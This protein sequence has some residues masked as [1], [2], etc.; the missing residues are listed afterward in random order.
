MK[1]I[2]ILE[3]I[4]SNSSNISSVIVHYD[5][6]TAD[7]ALTYSKKSKRAVAVNGQILEPTVTFNQ[8]HQTYLNLILDQ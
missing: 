1:R 8:T 2:L 3:P 7:T 5:L 6:Y 4:K